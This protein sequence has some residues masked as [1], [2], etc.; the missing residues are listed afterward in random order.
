MADSVNL[1]TANKSSILDAVYAKQKVKSVKETET[2]T[3]SNSNEKAALLDSL[4][5][6]SMDND[7]EVITKDDLKK[8]IANIK[9]K[10]VDDAATLKDYSSLGFA[11]KSS[12]ASKLIDSLMD[13][14]LSNYTGDLANAAQD[15]N[16][17]AQ[18][19]I[20][21]KFFNAKDDVN[22][23]NDGNTLDGGIVP[24]KNNL[25]NLNPKKP[26]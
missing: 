16:A 7:A 9:G 25:N 19:Y 11:S 24:L 21:K 4:S 6:A 10:L 13:E 12:A 1:D 26:L 3:D 23:S 22:L 14:F 2:E 18:Q 17:F 5:Q 20:N 15:F 8:E